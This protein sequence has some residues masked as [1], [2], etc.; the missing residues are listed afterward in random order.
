MKTPLIFETTL[1]KVAALELGLIALVCLAT[2]GENGWIGAINSALDPRSYIIDF[3]RDQQ[4][5]GQITNARNAYWLALRLSVLPFKDDL[6]RERAVQ[7]LLD[8]QS[9]YAEESI[10]CS[11]ELFK[12]YSNTLGLKNRHTVRCAADLL[13]DY[14][15]L[16]MRDKA[17][18]LAASYIKALG[19]PGTIKEQRYWRI[20]WT[21]SDTYER[22][23]QLEQALETKLNV[24]RLEERNVETSFYWID[25]ARLQIIRRD[26]KEAATIL[27]KTVTR[28]APCSWDPSLMK[29][30]GK[31]RL[32]LE[33][34]KSRKQ[35]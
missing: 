33:E 23:G 35:I 13:E 15:W 2:T 16:G 18:K 12:F 9:C 11:E 27:H 34:M 30:A 32:M 10:A 25:V 17:Q 31:A 4:S 20:L 5:Q 21:I 19:S 1:S 8:A 22:A 6:T 28:L 29:Q 26:Y 7:N 14:N 24:I 3:G